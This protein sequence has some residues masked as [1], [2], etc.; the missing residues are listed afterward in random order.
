[1]RHNYFGGSDRSDKL[2]VEIF[3][4]EEQ[5]LR[6]IGYRRNEEWKDFID[7]GDN[8]FELFSGFN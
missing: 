3:Q 2:L 4:M 6:F 1:M 8:G 7:V 5:C